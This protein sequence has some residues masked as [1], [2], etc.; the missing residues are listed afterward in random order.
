MDVFMKNRFNLEE[1]IS[2]LYSYVDHLSLIS[3]SILDSEDLDKDYITNAIEGIK[4]LLDM[5]I[6]KLNDTM[7]QV[8]RLDSYNSKEIV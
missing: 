7:C 2:G 5:H 3:E 8:F 4:V 6:K 1:E